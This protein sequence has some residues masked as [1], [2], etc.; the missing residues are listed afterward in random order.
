MAGSDNATNYATKQQVEQVLESLKLYEK[1]IV[2][3]SQKEEENELMRRYVVLKALS[4]DYI[5]VIEEDGVILTICAVECTYVDSLPTGISNAAIPQDY[6]NK[7]L[8]ST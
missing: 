1:Y 6:W 5:D 8:P 3:H 4:E 2:E 7:Y